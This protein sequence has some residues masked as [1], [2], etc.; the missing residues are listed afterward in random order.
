ML[1]RLT[2]WLVLSVMAQV[3]CCAAIRALLDGRC[4]GWVLW[5]VY[6][7]GQLT[8]LG[9][10][11]LM[12]SIYAMLWVYKNKIIEKERAALR[13]RLEKK[14]SQDINAH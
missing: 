5:L 2:P 12:G 14:H 9:C 8:A 13:E 11:F 10:F 4:G 1:N 3:M 6:A 7:V